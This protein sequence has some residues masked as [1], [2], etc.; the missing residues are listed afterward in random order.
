ME[1]N[2]IMSEKSMTDQY[3]DYINESILPFVD[4][5]KLHSS[6]GT[7]MVYAKE[8]LYLLH[9]AMV[10]TYGGES[11]DEDM[12]D[13]GFVIVPGIVCG[14]E[15]GNISLALLDL[16]LSSSGEHWGT[17]FL[18]RHG[19]VSQ[20]SDIHTPAGKDMST[21]IGNYD[22][23]YTAA[24]PNDIHID[25][26]A[27][28]KEVKA[29]LE[30]FRNHKADLTRP[31]DAAPDDSEKYALIELFGRKALFTNGRVD[32][33]GLPDGIFCYDIRHSDRDDSIPCSLE[34]FVAVNH[35]GTILC[36]TDFGLREWGEYIKMSYDESPN[37]LGEDMT[38]AEY[39][40]L[41]A[42]SDEALPKVHTL[43]PQPAPD[44]GH[45]P[46]DENDMEI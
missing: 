8:V 28:P 17:S 34:A 15:T 12:G 38:L 2:P 6:Y 7:D 20:S 11:L 19:V 13:E 39:R 9:E 40:T 10:K 30:D 33:N 46:D 42:E 14:K 1:E 23:C 43:P 41:Q 25:K 4:Y 36:S 22:Y 16:D 3:V 32:R 27:L 35:F 5:E 37:F 45:E 26:A 24:I 18:C 44:S 31:A 21:L 29:I